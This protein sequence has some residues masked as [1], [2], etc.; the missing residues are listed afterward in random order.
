GFGRGAGLNRAP[1][2][3][4]VYGIRFLELLFP[5]PGNLFLG[6]WVDGIFADRQHGSN[7]TETRNYLGLVTLTLALAWL[8]IAWRTWSSLLPRLRSTTAGL[9]GVFVAAL[10]LAAP[11]PISILGHELWMPSRFLWEIVPAVRVPSRWMALAMTALVPLAALG[12][13]AA[14]KRLAGAGPPR[15]AAYALVL[16]VA[17]VSF[18][19]LT[20]HPTRPRLETSPPPRI[21][22]A[23][24]KLP[25]GIA[26]EYP[27]V[28]TNEHIIW[29]T[30]YRRPLLNN[31]G[32]GTQADQARRM[33]LNPR[34]PGVAESLA[35]LGVNAIITHRDALRYVDNASDVPNASWGPGYELVTRARDGSSLWRVVAPAAPVLVTLPG[36]FGEP[37]PTEDG[38]VGY[39]LVSPSGVGIIEF[40][41]KA[42]AT[43]RLQFAATPPRSRQI[44]RLVDADTELPFRLGGETNVA[45]LV[46]IPR[47][48]S[49]LTVK[50]D[51]AATS[52]KDAIVLSKPRASTAFGTPELVAELISPDPGF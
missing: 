30:V 24:R 10:L 29:Q 23:L 33:V 28:T 8:A 2:D 34:V 11:S 46:D 26:A 35:L 20:I 27:L 37:I 21:Y 17:L 18:V 47:G 45:V 41:A 9:I 51:P 1:E 39:P 40:S 38:L 49:F 43:V 4:R 42:P 12:L 3:L 15:P 44:L 13:Q 22:E 14:W 25:P 7:P 52:E 50:T 6:D 5:S 19:E 32:F 31:A 36:G 48:H 16:A